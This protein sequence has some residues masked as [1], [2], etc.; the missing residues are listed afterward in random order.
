MMRV[1][2]QIDES[3][4]IGKMYVNVMVKVNWV[5]MMYVI[6][7]RIFIFNPISDQHFYDVG[8]LQP[9]ER[10]PHIKC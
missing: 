6:F 8:T 1:N 3:D 5:I 10:F 9:A 2:G 7:W 4:I